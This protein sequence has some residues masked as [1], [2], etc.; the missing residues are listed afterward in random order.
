MTIGTKY[1]DSMVVIPARLQ[2]RRFPRKPLQMAGNNSLLQHTHHQARKSRASVVCV[3]SADPEIQDHCGRNGI[4]WWPTSQ[5]HM[6]GTHRCAEVLELVDGSVGIVINWQCDEPLVLPEWIDLMIEKII[7]IGA[8]IVTL[9]AS[10]SA[11]AAE[12]KNVAKVVVSDDRCMW[13]S[14]LPLYDSKAHI[15]I[16][17]FRSEILRKLGKM[18]RTNLSRGESLE[19]LAWLE[20]GYKISY[21]EVD[22]LPLAINTPHD[23]KRFADKFDQQEINRL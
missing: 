7:Q 19:Q 13:F 3:A 14:R 17:A 6:T 1:T 21:I 9:V 15:G 4:A 23:W 5:A 11:P 20:A 18:Q 12:N 2:S 22:H 16:Y 8:D 10:L